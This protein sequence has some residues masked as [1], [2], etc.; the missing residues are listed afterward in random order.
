MEDEKKNGQEEMMEVSKTDMQ[1][2]LS[3]LDTLENRGSDEV[4]ISDSDEDREFSCRVVLY[5]DRPVTSVSNVAEEKVDKHGDSVMTCSVVT[6]EA[7]GK[8][9]THKGVDYKKL[10]SSDS[11]TCKLIRTET[12]HDVIKGSLVDENVYNESTGSMHLTGRKVRLISKVVVPIHV[13]EW[14]GEEIKLEDANI[15]GN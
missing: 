6:L 3:R 5:K 10:T 4:I 12:K 14:R 11:E 7:D 9:K 13:V 1:K 15:S 8:H 2:L